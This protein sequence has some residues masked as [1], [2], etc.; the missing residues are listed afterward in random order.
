[1]TVSI[2]SRPA[3]GK[4]FDPLLPEARHETDL[5]DVRAEAQSVLTGEPA[6]QMA[7]PIHCINIRQICVRPVV[8]SGLATL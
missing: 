5:A 8:A 6:E 7:S 4:Q 2:V 3:P 1:M